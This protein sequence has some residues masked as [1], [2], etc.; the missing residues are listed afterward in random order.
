MYGTSVVDPDPV[1]PPETFGM[2]RIREKIIL[3]LD[4]ASSGSD[5]NLK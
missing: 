3:D 4:P 2:I 1:R 5:A